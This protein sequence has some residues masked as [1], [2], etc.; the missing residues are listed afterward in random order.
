MS[1]QAVAGDLRRPSASFAVAVFL[2]VFFCKLLLVPFSLSRLFPDLLGDPRQ[3]WEVELIQQVCVIG[4]TVSLA[5]GLR[6]RS[7]I[8]EPR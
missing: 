5:G 4:L 8:F 3:W 2:V 1:M 7:W 6:R